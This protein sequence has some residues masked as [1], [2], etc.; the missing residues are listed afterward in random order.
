MKLLKTIDTSPNPHGMCCFALSRSP[1][2]V[3]IP[4][5]QLF[6]LWH[7]P[8]TTVT[9]HILCH[10]NPPRH[11]SHRPTLHLGRV[12]FHQQLVTCLFL[13]RRSSKPS[14]SLKLI[15]RL[16]PVLPSTVRVRFLLQRQTREPSSVCSL[17][18]MDTSCISSDVGPCLLGSTACP[19]IRRLPFSVSLHRLKPSISSN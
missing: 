14:T 1:F 18:L 13:T 7:H 6:L 2:R 12:M 9:W 5:G 4:S 15:G 16:W 3:L 10:R 11:S 17:S 19:S 8:Q